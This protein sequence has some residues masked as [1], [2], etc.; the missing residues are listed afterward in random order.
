V[1]ALML[2]T[3]KKSGVV[4][5]RMVYNGKPT[6]EWLSRE[7]ATSPTVSLES[8]FLTTVIDAKE[9]RDVFTADIPNAFIQ[10]ELPKTKPG[11]ERVTMKI[12]GVLAEL[13]VKLAP[14]TYAR[15]VVEENGQKVLYVVVLKA[16]Y[17]ML[18]AALMWYCR[19]RADLESIGFKF[20]N[21]DPCVAN[22]RVN[23]KQH[24]VRFHVDDLMG[25]HI[26]SSVN[27]KFIKWLNKKYGGY[28]EVKAT[29]GKVHDYLGMTFDF[30]EPGKVSV[31]MTDY[32]ASMVEDF[33][34]KL[35]KSDTAP[36]PAADDLMSGSTGAVLDK[37]RAEEF[38]TMVARGLFLCKRARPDVHP[39]IAVL[40]TRVQKPTEGDWQKLI[41][42]LKY[43]NG[44]RGDKLTLSADDLRVVKWYVDASFAV[45]PDFKSHTG[46]V[47]TFG[48]GAIQTVSRKQKLNTRSSTEA[49]LV[50]ADDLSTMI[51]W[52][53][54][55]LADQ[56]YDVE[57][58]VLLQDNK[59]A[60]L[61]ETNG[62]K[63]ST[64]RTRALNIRYFFIADQVEKGNL[65]VEYCPT[66]EMVADFM[67]KPLQGKL[68]V[69]FRDSIM[70]VSSQAKVSDDRSVLGD[71]AQVFSPPGDQKRA[72][73]AQVEARMIPVAPGILVS[74]K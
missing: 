55:F 71:K 3:E 58:N 29:R 67:T 6:R 69:K 74:E 12:T 60:I 46:G 16:L 15:F 66:E 36:T 17:G 37:A 23:G 52:T 2:L 64:K 56:G 22:R 41:R 25:S 53:K 21:Y 39:A 73:G 33:S 19:F 18:V 14:E 63:S 54:L 28:G 59:S 11:Q 5:G 1:D 13:L 51:L 44:T 7:D 24:T 45:H 30:S 34:V 40:C 10:A 62:K 20:N 57:K 31:G 48:E 27:S 9:G 70:G 42:L 65:C 32:V 26:Q 4:K 49:E 35:G 38:H 47:M 72:F 8:I 68:F 61:L 50:G 43:C